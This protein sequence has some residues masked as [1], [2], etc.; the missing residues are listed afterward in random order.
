M[1]DILFLI[2]IIIFFLSSLGFMNLCQR[3]ME[4]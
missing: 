2:L 4:K 3:L 1:T